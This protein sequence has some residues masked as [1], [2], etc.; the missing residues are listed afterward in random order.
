MKFINVNQKNTQIKS[1]LSMTLLSLICVVNLFACDEDESVN[2]NPLNNNP[3]ENCEAAPSCGPNESEVDHCDFRE[4]NCSEFDMC[5]QTIFCEYDDGEND[6]GEISCLAAPAC[7]SDEVEVDACDEDDDNCYENSIC[8]QTIYCTT[9]DVE[10]DESDEDD[11]SDGGDE[12]D[13][14][15]GSSEGDELTC[16]A[17]PAC[18]P[19]QV[20]G[21]SCDEDDDS[22]QAVTL[23]EFTIFC[24]DAAE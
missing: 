2:N 16:L 8:D 19:N 3:E 21:E 24:A 14:D 5:G 23:C 7:G 10:G 15:D 13:E 17:A 6:D 9:D 11:E 18:G 20:E 1:S 22:C 12:S 4:A